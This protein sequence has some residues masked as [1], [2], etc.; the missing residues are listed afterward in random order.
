MNK[1]KSPPNLDSLFEDEDEAALAEHIQTVHGLSS[2]DDFDSTY[3]F[4]VLQ[5]CQPLNI[6]NLEYEWIS[7]MKT[8]TPFGLNIAKPYGLCELLMGA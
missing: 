5:I 2:S 6:E 3:Y 7:V 8:L 1:H 4:T